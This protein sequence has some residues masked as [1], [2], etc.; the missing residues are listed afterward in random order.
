MTQSR[1]LKRVIA[2]RMAFD[3]AIWTVPDPLGKASGV[4]VTRDPLAIYL[5]R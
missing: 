1:A 5:S 2:S 4:D 3:V